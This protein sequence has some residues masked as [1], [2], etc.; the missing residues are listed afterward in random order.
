MS[1]KSPQ[2][3]RSTMIQ[4][5]ADR[6][7][8]VGA[9]A[10]PYGTLSSGVR[11]PLMDMAI[12]D[13]ICY[14]VGS[15]P[16]ITDWLTR[17]AIIECRESGFPDPGPGY[18]RANSFSTIG[19]AAAVANTT[20]I[21]SVT[22]S[23]SSTSV[24]LTPTGLAP[25]MSVTASGTGT[26]SA[27]TY[28]VSITSTTIVLNQVPSGSGSA[29]L[30]F[31]NNQIFG[32]GVSSTSMQFTSAQ[33]MGDG[34]T[35]TGAASTIA[36]C[37]TV[38]GQNY[39]SNASGFSGIAVGEYITGTGVASGSQVYNIGAGTQVVLAAQV[40]TTN[41][42]IVTV[43]ST[44]GIYQNMLV[45]GT[46]VATGTQ[47]SSIVGTR[48]LLTQP[49]TTGSGSVT[50]T[51]TA[52]M[53]MTENATASAT[54]TLTFAFSFRRVEVLY[55]TVANGD[56][57]TFSI[58]GG[59][60]STGSGSLSTHSFTGAIQ[61]WDSGDLNTPATGVYMTG[62]AHTSG[63]GGGGVNII[64][65][66]YYNSAT[67]GTLVENFAISGTYI[68]SWATTQE[69][70][71]SGIYMEWAAMLQYMASI[72]RPYR[73]V[74]IVGGIND[75]GLYG[76]AAG[77]GS[78]YSTIATVVQAI[79][80]LTEVVMVAEYYGDGLGTFNTVYTYSGSNLIWS[81]NFSDP[82]L[83][84]P[85]QTC[86]M[87]GLGLASPNQITN[88]YGNGPVTI[89]SV[90]TTTASASGSVAS[91]GFTGVS[92]N[93]GVTGTGI[94]SGVYVASISGNNITFGGNFAGITG[95]TQNLTFYTSV[96]MTSNATATNTITAWSILGR[97]GPVFWATVN[98]SI[99]QAA[100]AT[101]SSFVSLWERFG[102][103]SPRATVQNCTSSNSSTSITVSS[104][105]FPGVSVGMALRGF[106]FQSG[107]IVSGINSNTLTLN[108]P[109]TSTGGM[110][111]DITFGEDIYGISL[112]GLHPVDYIQSQW[113]RDSHQS[114]AFALHER[115]AFGQFLQSPYVQSTDNPADGMITSTLPFN[116]PGGGPSFQGFKSSNDTQPVWQ[117][118]SGLL[119]NP[120]LGAGPGGTTALDTYL[121]RLA[122]GLW[123]CYNNIYLGVGA[124]VVTANAGTCT[125]GYY[126]NNFT[127]SS[128]AAMT[129]TIS[130]TNAY[131][132]QMMI[133]RIYDHAAGSGQG[134]T[135]TNATSSQNITLPSTSNG[136]TT[137][138]LTVALQYSTAGT[139]WYCVGY[140]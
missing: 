47:V 23:T 79:S 128:T 32:P 5:T 129:I 92:N 81:P 82:G 91:G 68:S 44:T 24:T 137:K 17:S 114:F 106:G 134:I 7:G 30:T 1:I 109:T 69:V 51:F 73:R 67:A 93:M 6:A 94:P 102:D 124:P 57:V 46:G 45:T 130:T 63:A 131:D 101:N 126:V 80:P 65:V 56:N 100:V 49:I 97:Q 78:S 39:V 41:S 13:S 135:W 20:V 116:F 43:T 125:T 38:S 70:S 107:T 117:L 127:N 14:G 28:I 72:G 123:Q 36:S 53:T 3:I 104:G 112:D 66:R 25:G 121:I 42:N 61:S 33:A 19:S 139:T 59:T 31:N 60:G 90:T 35:T 58:V 11:N 12:G 9:A 103:F 138:P 52:V 40:T 77:I 132:G 96:Q 120:G 2:S 50:L 54:N 122:A 64:G 136:S 113:G 88:V 110:I 89:N 84:T 26:L 119:A 29:N 76:T 75:A 86:Q 83:P 8:V 22:L 62:G 55:Q 95:G 16:G 21:N 98:N 18:R 74:Y 140:A 34:C 85:A 87:V 15:A 37:T 118:R 105:G 4:P 108:I 10:V 133:V 111:Q 48:I 71:G 115:I 99:Y 27:N